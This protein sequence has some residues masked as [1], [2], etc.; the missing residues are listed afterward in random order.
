MLGRVLNEHVK[1]ATDEKLMAKALSLANKGRGYVSPNPMVGAVV[2]L[3]GEVVGKGFHARFGRQHAEVVAL[4]NAG[5][6]A[7]TAT[8]YVN[9]EPCSHHGK[10]PPCVD[11]IVDAMESSDLVIT[12]GGS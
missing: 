8:L 12:S 3:E 7:R 11:A 4:A 9:L 5:H 6:K 2:V 1:A 10:T